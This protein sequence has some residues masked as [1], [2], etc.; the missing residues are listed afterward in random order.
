MNYSLPLKFIKVSDD[1]TICATRIIS[2]MSKNSKTARD[3]YAAE[4]KNKTIVDG[5]G[6][7]GKMMSLI[8]LDNGAIVASEKTIPQLLNQLEDVQYRK[9]KISTDDRI[10]RIF[11]IVEKD[12]P[13][14]IAREAAAIANKFIENKKSYFTQLIEEEPETVEEVK[15]QIKEAVN[16]AI[17]EDPTIETELFTD[18]EYLDDDDDGAYS[19]F[20]N[21][22]IDIDNEETEEVEEDGDN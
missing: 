16:R 15:E 7:C 1:M 10:M 18:D 14:T 17:D 12:T 6:R 20:L 4:R 22:E 11:D 19:R 5:R 9:H 13:E 8:F 21:S 3:I 2:I